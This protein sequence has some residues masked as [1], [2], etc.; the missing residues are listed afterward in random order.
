[1]TA[2][3]SSLLG[4]QGFLRNSSLYLYSKVGAVRYTTADCITVHRRL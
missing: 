4:E 2:R 1:M 3:A